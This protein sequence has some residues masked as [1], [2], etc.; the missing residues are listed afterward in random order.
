M[1]SQ[2]RNITRLYNVAYQSIATING[3]ISYERVTD[4][5]IRL[6]DMVAEKETPEFFL[7][8]TG[9]GNE[10]CLADLIIGA[11]WHYSQWHGG[12]SSK[13]YAALSSL[14][15]IFSPGIE[16]GP[17]PETGERS[18][19]ELLHQLAGG[20][21][22]SFRKFPDGDL[23]ALWDDNSDSPGFITSYQHIGQHSAASPEL[24]SE[25]ETA[26]SEEY[27][28]LLVELENRGY[29]VMNSDQIQGEEL[30]FLIQ[31][32]N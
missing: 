25:L 31:Y 16:S 23:I 2:L 18:A 21:V 14:G 15:R 6:A 13:G 20:I 22:V 7:Q 17:E 29:V 5:I 4:C 1:S 10:F 27:L 9:E 26:T 28:P 32:Q 3:R 12:Q 19:F 24:L 30:C 8:E 11:Y